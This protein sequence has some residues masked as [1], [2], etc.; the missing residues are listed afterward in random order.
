[1]C[2]KYFCGTREKSYRAKPL[3]KLL[4]A[5]RCWRMIEASMCTFPTCVGKSAVPRR[6]AN[7]SNR[8]AEWATSTRICQNK[9]QGSD[10]NTFR[11]NLHLLLALASSCGVANLC[12][13]DGDAA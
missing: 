2:S 11:K 7:A 5:D 4:L 9:I 12:T 8:C 3:P 10:E 1:T 13:A 6:V